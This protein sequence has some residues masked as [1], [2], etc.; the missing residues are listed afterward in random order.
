MQKVLVMYKLRPGV[1]L[2][3]YTSWSKQIDQRITPGQDGII[4]FE[5]YAVQRV[6]GPEGAQ[7]QVVED[8]DV[9]SWDAFERCVAGPGM[10]Y[11][12]ETF[13]RY[14]DE[15]TLVTICGNRIVA[16]LE[17]GARPSLPADAPAT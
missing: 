16:S 9:E 17:P 13:P 4:R 10:A 7:Y 1:T 6:N 14:A 15:S 11:V 12:Q 5:V 2:D 3:Q 8:I